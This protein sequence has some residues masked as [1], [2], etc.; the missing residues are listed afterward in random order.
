[1]VVFVFPVLHPDRPDVVFKS[2][3]PGRGAQQTECVIMSFQSEIFDLAKLHHAEL[4]RE[5]AQERQARNARPLSARISLR[6]RVISWLYVRVAQPELERA[7]RDH[8]LQLSRA[9]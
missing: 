9:R 7:Q 4:I 6:A 5:V 3:P 8:Q 1:M 2:A